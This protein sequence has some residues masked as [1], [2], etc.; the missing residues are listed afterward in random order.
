M[1]GCACLARDI[2]H[3]HEPPFRTRVRRETLPSADGCVVSRLHLSIWYLVLLLW[4]LTTA[5]GCRQAIGGEADDTR[6]GCPLLCWQRHHRSHSRL[7]PV[8]GTIN[9]TLSIWE[10]MQFFSP[11]EGFGHDVG[12]VQSSNHP[13]LF[14]L[15]SP[16]NSCPC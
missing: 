10:T 7:L 9:S 1:Q 11:C 15:S 2:P 3:K 4:I 5:A 16:H 13:P 6:D 12:I 8:S 14:P